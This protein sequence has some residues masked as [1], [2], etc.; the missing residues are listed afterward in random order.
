M[1]KEQRT[2]RVQIM[3]EPDEVRLIDNWRY[4]NRI[5]SRSAAVRE[6]VRRGLDPV[7]RHY[8][9]DPRRKSKDYG[10]HGWKAER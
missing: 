2:E 10:L 6:L 9:T 1:M 5:P 4:E 8:Q 3:L 7:S